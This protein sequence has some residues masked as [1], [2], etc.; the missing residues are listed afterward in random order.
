MATYVAFLRGIN[1]GGHTVKNDRLR[2]LF[3]ALGFT[4]VRTLL[5]S[6]NVLFDAD[7]VDAAALERR[8]EAQLRDGLGYAVPTFVRTG[9]QVAAIAG[10]DPFPDAPQGGKVHVGFL[11]Q[12]LDQPT[13]GEVVALAK[14]RDRVAFRDRELY[15]HVADRFMDS[16]LSDPAVDK[17]LAAAWTLR[18]ANTV[19]RIAAKLS[20]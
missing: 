5:A 13:R 16:A 19:Q 12:V 18:T 7:E 9:D 2:E 3:E 1:V 11:R 14:D 17:V 4:R 6:G 20:S 8:S 15:W 10:H